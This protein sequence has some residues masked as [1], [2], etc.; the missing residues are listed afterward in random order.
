MR[1]RLAEFQ[2]GFL[3]RR[4]RAEAESWLGEID[5]IGLTLAFPR[6]KR[7]EAK[8][9]TRQ[10]PVDLGPPAPRISAKAHGHES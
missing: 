3:T 9:Q 8:R 4:A 2:T 10:T 6:S 5:G 7:Q 1:G